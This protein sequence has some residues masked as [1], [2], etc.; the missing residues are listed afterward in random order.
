MSL[1]NKLE[2]SLICEKVSE[3]DFRE[4]EKFADRLFAEVGI[5]VEFTRHFKERVN[6]ARNITDITTEELVTLF[7]RSFAK[8]GDVLSK[9]GGGAEAVLHDARAQI[10]LPFVIR[11]DRRNQE[12]DLIAKT[13]MR[14]KHFRS[15]TKKLRF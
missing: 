2:R 15:A 5:D 14:K 6:D 4:I 1:S 13:V 11:W 7:K 10:N 8:Y 3:R 9:M 12:F